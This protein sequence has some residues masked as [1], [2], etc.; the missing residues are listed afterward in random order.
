[1]ISGIDELHLLIKERIVKVRYL[2][3]VTI[4]DMYNDIKSLLKRLLTCYLTYWYQSKLILD[5]LLSLKSFIE[6]NIT[7]SLS[8]YVEP[9]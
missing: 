6:R 4:D 1:M 2:P 8:L 5:E 7:P 9:L 3:G